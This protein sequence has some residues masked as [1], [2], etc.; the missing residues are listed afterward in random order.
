[1]TPA[2]RF[3]R[4]RSWKRILTRTSRPR[5]SCSAVQQSPSGGVC[6][7]EINDRRWSPS[8]LGAGGSAATI[9]PTYTAAVVV[10]YLFGAYDVPRR[11]LHGSPAPSTRAPVMP[12]VPAA[13]MRDALPAPATHL[14]GDGQ[15]LHARTEGCAPRAHANNVDSSE[16]RAYASFLNRIECHFWAVGEFVVKNADHPDWDALAKATADYIHL[17][18]RTHGGGPIGRDRSPPPRGVIISFAVR[19][20][21]ATH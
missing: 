7:D 9:A 17:R 5:P 10:R 4:T 3:Q 20:N 12:R 15:P 14:P 2:C 1:M 11:P 18:N 19:P 13:T 8:R 6:F 16:R 21:R